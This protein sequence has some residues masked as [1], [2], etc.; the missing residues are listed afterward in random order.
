MNE[1]LR[2]LLFWL[3]LLFSLLVHLVLLFVVTLFQFE[4]PVELAPQLGK[5]SVQLVASPDAQTESVRE[6]D[7]PPPPPELPTPE[8]PPTEIEV[9]APPPQPQLPDPEPTPKPPPPKPPEKP[10]KEEKPPEKPK[11]KT[12]STPSPAS[13]ASEGVVDQL[14]TATVNPTPPYPADALQRGQEGTVRLLLTIDATGKV[15]AARVIRSSGVE[16]LD[17]SALRTIRRWLFTPARRNGQAV[18]Y[19]GTKDVNFVIP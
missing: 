10:V 13:K 19:E 18:S 4:P 9:P 2:E 3:I 14:P 12:N 6:P 16:S 1:L 7:P 17:D 8:L 15:V 5:V 11:A